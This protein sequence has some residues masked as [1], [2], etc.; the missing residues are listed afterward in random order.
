MV[1]FLPKL[2]EKT[3]K[4]TSGL[5]NL[6]WLKSILELMLGMHLPSSIKKFSI[7]NLSIKNALTLRPSKASL[8]NKYCWFEFCFC[9]C[10]FD[11]QPILQFLCAVFEDYQESINGI[12]PKYFE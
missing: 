1:L 8:E 11:F 3:K 6:S 5:R 9:N 2:Q 4:L 10:C 12:L 7:R